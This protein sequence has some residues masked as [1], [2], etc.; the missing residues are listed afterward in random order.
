MYSSQNRAVTQQ[1]YLSLIYNMPP[2]FGSVKRASIVQ[3]L[4]SFKR[5]LNIYVVSEDQLGNFAPSSNTIK[6]NLK[7]WLSNNKMIND[8]IDILDA[9]I[10]NLGINFSIIADQGFNAFEVLNTSINQLK[11]YFL[12]AKM[13]IGEPIRYGDILRILKNVDGLLDVVHLEIVRK[14]GPSYSTGI[15]NI[16]QMT[17]SDGR[18]VIAPSDVVFEVKFPDSDIVGTII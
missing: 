13:N 2:K 1:D 17:T 12:S 14:I 15:F 7:V 10:I 11:F 8:T 18:T 3:D 5:N 9:K 6:N 4:N 16:D